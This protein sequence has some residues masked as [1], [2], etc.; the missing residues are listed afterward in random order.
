MMVEWL[1]TILFLQEPRAAWADTYGE[2]A[3]A[4]AT[5]VAEEK[6]LYPGPDGRERTAA[7]ML[8]TSWYEATWQPDAVGKLDE[9]CLFQVHPSNFR[10][11]GVTREQLLTDRVACVRAGYRLMAQSFRVCRHEKPE[12]ALA[13]FAAGGDG[14]REPGFR[15]SRHRVWLGERLMRL[16]PPDAEVPPS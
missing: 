1:L 16:Y 4:I 7:L 6:P 13:H 14:C 12:L 11:L 10:A 15:P 3:A 2:T 5:V 9:A 8:A